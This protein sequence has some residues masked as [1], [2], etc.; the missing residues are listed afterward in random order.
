MSATVESIGE[1]TEH[2]FENVSQI[3]RFKSIVLFVYVCFVCFYCTVI[4]LIINNN[5]QLINEYRLHKRLFIIDILIHIIET[6]I[7]NKYINE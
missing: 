5:T 3:F 2:L 1:S 4:S 7:I 6:K